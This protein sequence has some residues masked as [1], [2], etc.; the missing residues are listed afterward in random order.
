MKGTTP[1]GAQS[2]QEAASWVRD[3]FGRVAHRYDLANHLLS[4]NID[5][6]WRAHTAA[7]VRDVLTRPS[8][9]V[10]DICCG[11]GDLVRAL[12]RD[13]SAD[14]PVMGSDFCHPMLVAARGKLGAGKLFEA[15]ALRLPLAD[16]S[17]DLL[18]VAF[19][20]RN[21]AN[22]DAGLCEMRRVLRAGGTAAILEFSQPPN[23]LFG[24]LYNFYSRRVLPTIGGALS[25]SRDAY[26][27]LPESVRKF[28]SPD[29]L[30]GMMRAAGFARVEFERLTGGIVA[31]HLGRV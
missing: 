12:Q 11:T 21:L 27:Y 30:A 2:E 25:G 24:G 7:R 9:R 16:A 14:P 15:D 28:P 13:R 26:T 19:G 23:P 31:L 22:Y 6:Y 10:L 8:A 3:M 1:E 20:F 17:L 5:R 29:E 4:L 18:T